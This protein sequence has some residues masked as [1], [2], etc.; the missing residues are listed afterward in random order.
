MSDTPELTADQV[1]DW[2]LDHPHFF[3]DREELLAEIG[4]A[5]V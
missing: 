3:A 4:R 1:A 5:H 2:L